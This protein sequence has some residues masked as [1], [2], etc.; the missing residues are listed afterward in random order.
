MMCLCV[1]LPA[2]TWEGLLPWAAYGALGGMA[3]TL[4]CQAGLSLWRHLANTPAALRR[5]AAKARSDADAAD[6]AAKVAHERLAA[7]DAEVANRYLEEEARRLRKATS[8]AERNRTAFRA[9]GQRANQ[10]E[11]VEMEDLTPPQNPPQNP[12]PNG[13]P[14]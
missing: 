8:D 12:G 13:E 1:E 4:V 10:Q 6:V 5:R 14:T 3:V 11:R 2:V 7:K 9:A